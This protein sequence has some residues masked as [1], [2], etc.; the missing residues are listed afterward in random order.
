MFNQK[1]MSNRIFLAMAITWTVAIMV[2]CWIPITIHLPE[3][4]PNGWEILLPDLDK[5][6]HFGI[7]SIFAVLW[8]LAL[9]IPGRSWKIF[10]AAIALAIVTELVQR[11]P[12][13]GRSCDL[14][15]ALY[16]IIG[17]IFALAFMIGIQAI[18]NRKRS[19]AMAPTM[20]A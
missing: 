18:V 5:A 1:V 3:R 9:P 17:V 19:N 4:D 16:D 13:V 6:V 8:F 12:I 7:F 11:L 15:D 10:I 2:M 20:T 14:D